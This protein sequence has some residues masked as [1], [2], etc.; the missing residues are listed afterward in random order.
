MI[1]KGISGLWAGNG[2]TLLP[3]IETTWGYWKRLFPGT[4]VISAQSSGTFNINRYTLYP[5]EGYRLPESG[6]LF[7][8]SPSSEEN[9]IV[10]DHS[11]KEVALGLRFGQIAKAYP[12][13]TM[14][15]E[16]VVI[17]DT[18]AGQDVLILYY[19]DG[20]LALPYQRNVGGTRL[21]FEKIQSTDS[22]FP[23]MM[24]DQETG[25]IWN[26]LGQGISGEMANSQLRQIAAHN[27]FWFAWATFWQETEVYVQ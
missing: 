27:T 26:M 22:R 5:Y 20:R 6:P 3:V 12:F 9:P 15:G 18:V 4:R 11:P 8:L 7:P 24:R 2:L 14:G 21:T 10:L 19:A 17:N 13:S 23:F 16:E 1:Y 25:T